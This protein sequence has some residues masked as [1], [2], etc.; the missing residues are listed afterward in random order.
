MRYLLPPVY[1]TFFAWFV[2][3]SWPLYAANAP[4]DPVPGS[5]TL[6]EIMEREQWNAGPRPPLLPVRNAPEPVAE[7]KPF[8]AQ[9][10]PVVQVPATPAA[11]RIVRQVYPLPPGSSPP[12]R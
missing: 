12:K 8:P 3:F 7:A 4:I 1:A 9:E 11:P 6:G 2:L 10:V 5:M